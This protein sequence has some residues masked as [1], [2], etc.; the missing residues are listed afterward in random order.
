MPIERDLFT[1]LRCVIGLAGINKPVGA[2][3][4]AWLAKIIEGQT[5]SDEQRSALEQDF[6]RPPDFL[7]I[8]K[9]IAYFYDREKVI[10]FARIVFNID[11]E[12]SP[13]EKQAFEALRNTHRELSGDILPKL[14]SLGSE[15]ASREKRKVF[16]NDLFEAGEIL[17]QRPKSFYQSFFTDNLY[18][19][20][21]VSGNR[22]VIWF[23]V[24]FFGV[25]IAAR[26]LLPLLLGHK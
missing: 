11:G 15:L 7:E 22:L 20:S 21:L 13:I 2:K 9:G 18:I 10:E 16:F 24:I 26:V 25:A 8:F 23:F 14:E 5:F 17:A 19:R 1:I 6:A 4:R 12:F 3:E